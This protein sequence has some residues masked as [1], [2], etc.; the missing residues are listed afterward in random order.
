MAIHTIKNNLLSISVNSIGAELTSLKS[1]DCELLWQADKKVWARYAPVL[2]PVVGKLK[3]DI[4]SYDG[5]QYSLSQHGFARDKE[6]TLIYKDEK[7]LEFELTASESTLAIFPFHFSLIIQYELNGNALSVSYRVFNP[8]NKDLL[9]SIGA[10]P[11]FS[12]NRVP[13]ENIHDYK[14]I[15]EPKQELHAQKLENGLITDNGYTLGLEENSLHLSVKLFDDD[16]IVLKDSQVNSVKL[17]S[18]KSKPVIKMNCQG[19]PYFGIWAKRGSHSFVCLE[20]WYGIADHV[21]STRDITKK[22]GIIRLSSGKTFNA[23]YS[24]EIG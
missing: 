3:D 24:L 8:D 9:F 11:G 2:F 12:C 4:Y 14:L 16:A 7:S 22:E 18:E 17:V 15:F 20:P 6:F 10:H 13:N 19:W 1:S 5:N 23:G 21:N